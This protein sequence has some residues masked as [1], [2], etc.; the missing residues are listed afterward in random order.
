[1]SDI[2]TYKLEIAERRIAELERQNDELRALYSA[3]KARIEA[4]K[5]SLGV[6]EMGCPCCWDDD[7]SDEPIER[8][9]AFLWDVLVDSTH[10]WTEWLAGEPTDTYLLDGMLWTPEKF[11][12]VARGLLDGGE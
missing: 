6:V 1:M 9:C 10:T 7:P 8:A 3:A 5:R 12:E 4:A 11:R 2:A